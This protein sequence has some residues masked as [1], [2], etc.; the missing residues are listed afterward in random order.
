MLDVNHGIAKSMVAANPRSLIGIEKLTGIRERTERN[1]DGKA[2]TK[3]RRAN[4]KKSQWSFAELAAFLEYKAHL[5]GGMV[6]AVEADY[7]SQA[8]VKCG[9]TSKAN[10]P[11]GGLL[12]K[13]AACGYELH[14]DLL[15]ARNVALR[16]LL[17]RQDWERTGCLSVTPGVHEDPLDA[18][19]AEAKAERL[20][21]YS[22]LRWSSG[23]S[24]V[25][26]D[27]ATDSGCQ[28]HLR[29]VH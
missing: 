20:K 13:C 9:H 22:E 7:T 18:S 16:V 17:F 12:F 15:G 24:P 25:G 8:C 14:A 3:R 1:T 21:R 4:R 10:R 11:N 5:A 23:T 19:S 27:G 28:G 6:V 2:S 26:L 29:V